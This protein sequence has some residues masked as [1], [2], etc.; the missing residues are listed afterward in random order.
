LTES[1]RK[2]LAQ[3]RAHESWAQTTDRAGRT[4]NARRALEEKFVAEADGDPVRAEHLRRAFY[5]RLAFKSAQARRKAKE[6]RTQADQ[7]DREAS[8][9]D[10]AMRPFGGAA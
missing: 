9:A 4:A 5:A 3:I 1:E 10:A 8:A 2:L 7:L 6:A